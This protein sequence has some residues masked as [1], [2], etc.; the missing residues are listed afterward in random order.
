MLSSFS[1][2]LSLSC[3]SAFRS[4]KSSSSSIDFPWNSYRNNGYFIV[5]I[6]HYFHRLRLRIFQPLLK[7]GRG[8]FLAG[9]RFRIRLAFDLYRYYLMSRI[10]VPFVKEIVGYF[11]FQTEVLYGLTVRHCFRFITDKQPF[12]ITATIHL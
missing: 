10:L 12:E 8:G 3:L 4:A 11:V 1:R 7:W 5:D 9:V 2:S 6:Y